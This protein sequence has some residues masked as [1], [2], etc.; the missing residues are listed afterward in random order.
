MGRDLSNESKFVKIGR[1]QPE[2][3]VNKEIASKWKIYISK[4]KP[5]KDIERLLKITKKGATRFVQ[6]RN[7]LDK[8]EWNID[9]ALIAYKTLRKKFRFEVCL[10]KYHPGI[11][12]T[13]LFIFYLLYKM[14]PFSALENRSL[15]LKRQNLKNIF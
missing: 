10:M 14:K 12:L 11:N 5:G 13:T 4:L 8:T 3:W 1:L 9:F 6:Q 15:A 7:L 2:I